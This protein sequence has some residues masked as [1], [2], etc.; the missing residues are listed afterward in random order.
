[1]NTSIQ[2][3]IK[4]IIYWLVHIILIIL[5]IVFFQIQDILFKSIGTSL[6]AAGIAGLVIFGYIIFTQKINDKLDV[7]SKYGIEN[8]FEARA[9]RIKSTY[10]EKLKNAK[11]NIDV[12]GFGLNALREDYLGDFVKWK[13]SA[14]VRILLID[15]DYPTEEISLANLRD[16]EE[17]D[18]AGE[19]KKEVNQF[20][21]DVDNIVDENFEIR[22]YRCLP[23]VN[24]FRVDDDLFWGPYLMKEQSRNTP[25]IL[26]GSGGLLFDKLHSHFET[27]WNDDTLSGSI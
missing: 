25:T 13:A 1:M 18:A 22:L 2:I 15:P 11:N 4:Y 20:I 23:S 27:I 8:I 17:G 6:I 14:K 21:K 26:V 5:G 9:A 24:I 10:D 19:I 16:Q 7:I 12:L 3:N